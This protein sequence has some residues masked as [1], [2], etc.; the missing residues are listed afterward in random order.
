[1]TFEIQHLLQVEFTR[2]LLVGRHYVTVK[3]VQRDE[4]PLVLIE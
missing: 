4:Q 3:G 2:E 1:M